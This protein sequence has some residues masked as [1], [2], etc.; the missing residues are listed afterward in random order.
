MYGDRAAW[1]ADPFRIN[2]R[3]LECVARGL[4]PFECLARPSGQTAPR[5][6]SFKPRPPSPAPLRIDA[7]SK[8]VEEEEEEEG[9][10]EGDEWGEGEGVG[11][12][13]EEEDEEGEGED[14]EHLGDFPV[15]RPARPPPRTS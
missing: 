6:S 1:P 5:T 13:E 15:G 11:G 2:M 3:H 14:G 10:E 12:P 9:G 7:P 8:P 4:I